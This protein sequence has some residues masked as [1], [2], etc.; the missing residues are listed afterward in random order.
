MLFVPEGF[1]KYIVL[2]IDPGTT[3]LGVSVLSYD[4]NTHLKRVECAFTLNAG[5]TL[6]RYQ[7]IV[8]TAGERFARLR[9][10]SINIAKALYFYQPNE[11]ITEVPYMGRFPNAYGALMECLH[12][13]ETTVYEWNPFVTLQGV[14]PATVKTHM[15]VS[16]KSGDK[17]LMYKAL[18]SLPD[19][20]KTNIDFTSIDEHSVDAT[21]VAYSRVKQLT[22]A[23]TSHGYLR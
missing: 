6:H 23:E 17:E 11:V 8:E 2:G 21:A 22:F 13:V 9:S 1:S 4:L 19:L 7:P 15:G 16:G 18:L 10:H 5:K 12:M 14:D 3:T 20:D